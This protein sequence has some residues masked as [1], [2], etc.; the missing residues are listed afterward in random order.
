MAHDKM[1]LTK[2]LLDAAPKGDLD[3]VRDLLENK[4]GYL[5]KFAGT[6]VFESHKEK[7]WAANTCGTALM[8][9]AQHEQAEVVQ[10]LLENFANDISPYMKISAYDMS[11]DGGATQALLEPHLPKHP[12]YG[13]DTLS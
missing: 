5:G 2:Q 8:F 4:L 3:T 7:E 10:Y 6:I 11:K 1:E 12:H 9:A 13:L